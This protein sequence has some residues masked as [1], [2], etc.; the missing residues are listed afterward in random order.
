MDEIHAPIYKIKSKSCRRK[1]P[2]PLVEPIVIEGN[3]DFPLP[4]DGIGG[5]ARIAEGRCIKQ[6]HFE[7]LCFDPEGQCHPCKQLHVQEVTLR[8]EQG[9]RPT[10]QL[11]GGVLEQGN[12]ADDASRVVVNIISLEILPC[13]AVGGVEVLEILERIG[14]QV[15]R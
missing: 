15:G 13:G 9:R 14:K 2:I 11:Q 3:P 1:S 6:A 5:I 4:G 7:P 8:H 12:F 10:R